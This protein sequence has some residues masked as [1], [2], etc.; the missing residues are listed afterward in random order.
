MELTIEQLMQGK[1]T[2][3][4]DKEY[5]TTEAYVTSVYRQSI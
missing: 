4:K 5:F 2:R 3:I 1:A